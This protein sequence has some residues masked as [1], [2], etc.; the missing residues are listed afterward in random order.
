MSY[1]ET[2]H[3]PQTEFPMR[4]NLGQTEPVRQAGWQEHKLY[5]Q[6]L[7]QNKDKPLFVLHDGP[8]YANGDIHMGHAL[9]KILK[10]F[11]VR[12]KNMAGFLAPYTPGWDTH[13]LPIENAL[14]KKKNINRK[15]MPVAEFR[16]LCS[17][18]ANEQIA[19]QKDQFLRLGVMGDFENFYATNQP[20]YEALQLQVFATMVEQGLI[21]KGLKPVYW[22]PSSETALAEA[23]IEYHDHHS[24]SIYVAMPVVDG[25]GLVDDAEMVIWT[26]TPWTIPANLANCVGPLIDY[27]LIEADGRKLLVGHALVETLTK[28]LGWQ[29]VKPLKLLQGKDLE[30]VTYRHPLYERVSPVILGDHVTTEDGTGIV[31]TAPGHGAD[32]FMVGKL[33]GLDVYSPVNAQ[34]VFDA[35]TG[36]EGQFVF[37]AN[38]NITKDLATK[39]ALLGQRDV[40]HSYPHDWRTNKPIIF[41]ATPQWFASIEG[42]KSKLLQA[43]KDTTW[44]PAWGELRM[45]NMIKDREEWCISRQ[46]VWGVPIPAFYAEDGTAILDPEVIRHVATLFAE[47]GSNIWF[48][49]DAKAL[50]P[51]GYTHPGSPSGVFTKETDIMDVWFDSGTSHHGGLIPFGYENKQVD[52]YLEGSDQ[53]RGWFNSSLSTFVATHGTAPYKAVFSH[54]FINDEQGKKMSKSLG[55][56]IDPADITK[57]MGADILR[58]WVASVEVQQD[59]RIS[60][61]VLTQVSEQ[62]RKVRNTLRFLLGNLHD[63]KAS[64]A[65]AYE[66][67]DPMDQL[68]LQELYQLSNSVQDAYDAYS[69]DDVFRLINQYVNDLSGFYLDF[70]KDILYIEEAKSERRRSVQT[71]YYQ[72]TDSLIRLINPI[73]PHTADEA[74]SY[75]PYASANFAQ[76]LSMPKRTPVDVSLLERFAKFYSLRDDILK[77]LEEARNE[78]VI[79]K[80]FEA[81]LT[82]ALNHEWQS[83]VASLSTNLQQAL[84]VSQLTI[85][86]GDE[87]AIHITKA[88]GSTCER[89]WQVVH[90]VED[91]LCSRCASI[92]R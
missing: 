87:V 54:G 38:P 85:V 11:V 62:Y 88:E 25:K 75:L 42:L 58:L 44:M 49:L 5:E 65:V 60:Q 55:N 52:L 57:Q 80:S 46:R 81:H 41:R 84:I 26:T 69:F 79:G 76:L 83:Y 14:T 23:E 13:G 92:V 22:S 82:L 6:L 33:Y 61:H 19:R 40:Y 15:A 3:M 56:G 1:K 7:K 4:G 10:D 51:K 9:N 32:D 21:Y 67:L 17:A 47:H 48:E 53:Y 78:K 39:G 71:V 16:A 2:L 86:E 12:Y 29:S 24:P 28:Q 31:H 90:E 91:G 43:V 36:Y 8:P 66:T 37:D 34:G 73:L 30:G 64:D 18:Y 89:C 72:I 50:L 70:T 68:T 63:F 74:L 35:D 77:A 59:V 45:T 20:Q 27:A